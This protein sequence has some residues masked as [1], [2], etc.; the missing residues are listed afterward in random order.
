MKGD[1]SF[2]F[3]AGIIIAILVIFLSSA[4]LFKAYSGVFATLEEQIGLV[5]YSPIEQQIICYYYLCNY[6]CNSGQFEDWCGPSGKYG[7][8]EVYEEICTLPI[9]LGIDREQC[10]KAYWQFPI[11]IKLDSENE[12]SMDRLKKRIDKKFVVIRENEVTSVKYNPIY[13]SPSD[14]GNVLT[15]SEYLKD[16][17]YW[18]YKQDLPYIEISNAIKYAKVK[19]SLPSFYVV[20]GLNKDNVNS[21]YFGGFATYYS[22]YSGSSQTIDVEPPRII[23]LSIENEKEKDSDK[24]KNYNYVLEIY[25]ESSM[26]VYPSPP[27]LHMAFWNVTTKQQKDDKSYKCANVNCEDLKGK[28]FKFI[29][30]K[31]K[32]I[33][34][35]ED[36]EPIWVNIPLGPVSITNID[37]NKLTINIRYTYTYQ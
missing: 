19:P 24:L 34:R 33:V 12:L 37:I 22:F 2:W 26:G 21:I 3:I 16:K 14:F 17:E 35:I 13:V 5:R 15:L 27:V 30:K 25:T 11:K 18:N 36:V 32:V 8:S 31:G 10:K 1:V 7:S 28:E 23:R 9:E 4:G 6:G 20:M 29:T